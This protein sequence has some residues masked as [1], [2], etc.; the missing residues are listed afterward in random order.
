M[1]KDK[2]VYRDLSYKI[3]GVLFD[4]YNELG[5]GYREKYYE[6]AIAKE[7]KLKGLKFKRQIPIDI[8]YKNIKIGKAR[9]DFLIEDKIILEIKVGKYFTKQNFE[10]IKSYIKATN[11]K[12]AILVLFTFKGVRFI[13]ILN[14]NNNIYEN[15]AELPLIKI[16]ELFK[17]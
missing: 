5:F 2:V 17:Y 12:L 8:R 15:E 7:L 13:R 10:Q 9:L 11:R 1:K 4:V 14:D 6:E 3:V 16:R